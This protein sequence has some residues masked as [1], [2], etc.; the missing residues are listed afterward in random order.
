MSQPSL[1]RSAVWYT[2]QG[3]PVF[4]L[5]PRTK[6]TYKGIGVYQAS[7][8]LEQV[9]AWWS[10]WPQANIGLHV[11]GAGLLALDLDAY[12]ES[13]TG[14][15]FL[16]SDDQQTITNLTGRGGTHL[17]F[18]QPEGARLGNGTGK[19]PEGIDVRGW[20]GYVVLPPSVHPNGRP[21]CWEI[22]Y[23]PHEIAARPAPGGLLALLTPQ[24]PA[25]EG[26]GF[27][28]RRPTRLKPCAGAILTATTAAGGRNNTAWRLALHLRSDGWS[29]AS[30]GDLMGAWS[31]RSGMAE[32]EVT[33]TIRSAYRDE[34][35]PGH[36]CGSRELAPYC[37]L[38][39][40]LAR[41]VGSGMGTQR[42]QN[43]RA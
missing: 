38:A 7:T 33:A 2:T 22:G 11:G 10:R 9:A 4:P 15:A 18:A 35:R 29:E 39:C 6:D 13:Y 5:R 3:W 21:Y 17:L 31:E 1:P 27:T 8:D 42:G 36:G 34:R 41:F 19:L 12:K 24:R 26:A 23:G 25:G 28:P 16:T 14:A 30:A 43:E 32:R 40:P 20:G 37:D